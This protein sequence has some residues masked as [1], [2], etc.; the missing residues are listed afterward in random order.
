MVTFKKDVTSIAGKGNIEF[1]HFYN[2][3]EC[4]VVFSSVVVAM[5]VLKKFR[6]WSE[7]YAGVS[8]QGGKSGIY[9]GVDVAFAKDF[10]EV[11]ATLW[12]IWP[13][14]FGGVGRLRQ[15]VG[16]RNEGVYE[17]PVVDA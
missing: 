5:E 4:T 15:A 11:P 9:F 1:F 12:S 17:G 8:V 16:D 7:E 13:G 10:N 2:V 3:G 14:A 6:L